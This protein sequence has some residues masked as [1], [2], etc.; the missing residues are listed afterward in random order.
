MLAGLLTGALAAGITSSPGRRAALVLGGSLLASLAAT[1]IVQGW[2]DVVDGDWVAN[3]AGLSLM[4]L[5]IAALTTGLEALMGTVGIL[6]S[7]L[8]MVF[9][10]NPF[11]A[12]ATGHEMLP[13]PRA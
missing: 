1:A 5:A 8:A 13:T 10:G 2:L 9:I 3:A 4:V 12:V 11:S 6:V 7:A